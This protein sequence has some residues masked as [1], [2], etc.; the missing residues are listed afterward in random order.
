MK[1][2]ILLFLAGIL[3]LGL[4]VTT[5]AEEKI[6]YAEI[7]G[8]LAE[9]KEEKASF[10]FGIL[11]GTMNDV[12]LLVEFANETEDLEI[13]DFATDYLFYIATYISFYNEE[14]NIDAIIGSINSFYSDPK[15]KYCNP[16]SLA[17]LCYLQLQG[18]DIS[19][20]LDR[21]RYYAEVGTE[22]LFKK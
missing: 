11:C 12:I 1:K 10:I 4:I 5:G 14:D 21:L 8:I 17:F 20:E 2:I 7:W 16:A 6:D 9:K 18:K 22:S 19:K 13:I 15:N 3:F